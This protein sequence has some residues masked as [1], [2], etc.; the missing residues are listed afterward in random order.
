V[1]TCE[2]GDALLDAAVEEIGEFIAEM[3]TRPRRP[4]RDHH[5]S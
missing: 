5:E 3:A 2:K 1:A 4:G